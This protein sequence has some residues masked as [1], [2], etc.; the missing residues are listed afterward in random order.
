MF[1]D[2]RKSQRNRFNR[3]GQ[4]YHDLI[5]MRRCTIVN[6]SD[7]GARLCAEDDLPPAFVLSISTDNGERRRSC[8]VVWRLEHEYGV[9]FDG[10]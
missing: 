7:G 9:Q 6:L 3:T 1:P 8:K 2:R 4:V 10:Q 5:G